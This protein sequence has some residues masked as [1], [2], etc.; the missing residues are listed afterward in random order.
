MGI[1]WDRPPLTNSGIMDLLVTT[2]KK[3]HHQI[4]SKFGQKSG[5]SI[6]C[7]FFFDV[8]LA[9]NPFEKKDH[10]SS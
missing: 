3:E 7:H 10:Q 2:L 4:Q 9:K 6:T 1:D 5:P 8:N